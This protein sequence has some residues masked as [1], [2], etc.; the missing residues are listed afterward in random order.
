MSSVDTRH[1]ARD[2]LFLFADLTF[3]GQSESTR[4]KVRN[5]SA[6]GMMAESS[7]I[8]ASRGDRL[9][10]DLRNVGIVRGSVAWTQGNRFGVAFESDIDPKVVRAPIGTSPETPRYARPAVS[11]PTFSEEERRIRNL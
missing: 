6:G 4:V 7:E 5:L 1:V 3:E 11:T 10:I 2:S 8:V 9:A